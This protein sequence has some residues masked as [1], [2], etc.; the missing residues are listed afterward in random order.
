VYI[1]Y[2]QFRIEKQGKYPAMIIKPIFS[3]FLASDQLS[4]IDNSLLAAYCYNQ[5]N[6]LE[7]VIKSNLHGWQSNT[8]IERNDQ[9]SKLVKSVLE[10][11]S[12]LKSKIGFKDT[13]EFFISNIWANINQTNASNRPHVHPESI[14]AGVYYVKF[15][16]NGGMITFK[17][18]SMN[19]QYHID[20]DQLSDY[21]EWASPNWHVLPETGLLLL[22]PSW[23]EHYV[24]PNL[25][26][27]DRISIA[28]NIS[29]RNKE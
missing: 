25:S 28:F 24:D 14:I 8:L 12:S 20:C 23:L 11:S 27:E 16:E 2:L 6:N 15:P 26:K 18:P 17:N 13:T 1:S 21:N 10:K 22:F 5:K 7:G 19:L 29:I 9:I 4:E 3:F